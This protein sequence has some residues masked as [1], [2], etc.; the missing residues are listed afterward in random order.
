[1]GLFGTNYSKPGPGI[2]KNAPQK[3]GIFRFFEIFFRK[4]W[5][6]IQVNMLTFIC[7][8]PFLI[9]MYIIAPI[10][11]SF[12]NSAIP[13]GAENAAEFGATLHLMLRSL[14]AVIVFVFWGSGPASAAYAYIT[15]C[16]T[17]EQHAWIL[18]DFK[19]KFLENFKQAIIVT[20]IDIILSVLVMY[21]VYFYYMTYKTTGAE[22]WLIACCLMFTLIVLYTFMHF[23]IYQFMVTFK[24]TIVQLYRNSLIFSLAQLPMNIVLTAIAVAIN[25]VM[26]SY[27]NPMFVLLLDFVLGISLVRFPIEY[28][29]AR[30]IEKKLLPNIVQDEPAE[31]SIFDDAAGTGEGEE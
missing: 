28:T 3:K 1:M 15:R 20:V 19:D 10:S 29:A 4:F 31:E 17:R 23:Y 22:I 21:G 18:S 16:F 13:Q 27:L 24:S 25:Y 5:K 6:L 8:L 2:D 9:I 14:F 12:I 7:S 11:D 30:A 26:F